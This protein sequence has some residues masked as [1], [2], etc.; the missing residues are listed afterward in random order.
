MLL[1]NSGTQNNQ[2]NL[3]F[4]PSS[5]LLN[6]HR[7]KCTMQLLSGVNFE[8]VHLRKLMHQGDTIWSIKQKRDSFQ[9]GSNQ[10]CD[11][12]GYLT[13]RE[14]GPPQRLQNCQQML[15]PRALVSYC[16]HFSGANISV[17]QY[18]HPCT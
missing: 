3:M 14:E 4:S 16:C 17:G 18:V 15:P 9:K 1:I 2:Q 13:Y 8:N 7:G 10:G 11:T 12:Q 6:H 5:W